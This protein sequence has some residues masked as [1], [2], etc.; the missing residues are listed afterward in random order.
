MGH[1][2]DERATEEQAEADA[3]P[4]GKVPAK[5]STTAEPVPPEDEADPDD[6]VEETSR[7]SYPGSDAPAW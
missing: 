1:D 5:H 2:P 3:H 6:F 7:D 4:H